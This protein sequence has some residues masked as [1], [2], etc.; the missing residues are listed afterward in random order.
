[1][2]KVGFRKPSIKKRVKARTTG[3]L[4]RKVKSSVNPLY[5]KK[6]MGYIKNPKRAVYNKVYNKTTIDP[7]KVGKSKSNKR[8]KSKY[9]EKPINK[10]SN[11]QPLNVTGGLGCLAVFLLVP[12]LDNPLLFL[13]VIPLFIIVAKRFYKEEKVAEIERNNRVKRIKLNNSLKELEKEKKTINTNSQ[14]N[15]FFVKYSRW[16]NKAIDTIEYFKSEHLFNNDEDL[17]NK[18]KE[19]MDHGK[20]LLKSYVDKY[21]AK[22]FTKAAKL[23]TEKGRRN[24]YKRSLD[25]L[26]N[27]DEFFDDD[28]KVYIADI[29]QKN[30]RTL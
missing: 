13:L 16:R 21:E 1:M 2:V 29:W 3:K 14:I 27:Y 8:T 7:L 26:N 23:K 19:I 5:G 25:E 11:D 15:N 20:D 17:N 24:N 28:L 18:S 30:M 12:A 4:K 9:I 10:P 22:A 6:G